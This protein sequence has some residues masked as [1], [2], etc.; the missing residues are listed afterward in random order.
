MVPLIRSSKTVK[1]KIYYLLIP[2]VYNLKKERE[3]SMIILTSVWD[4]KKEI[5]S[6]RE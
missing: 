2:I 6:G 3:N 1:L 5:Q 4:K